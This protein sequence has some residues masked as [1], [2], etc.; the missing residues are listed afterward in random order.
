MAPT[1]FHFSTLLDLQKGWHNIRLPGLE[2]IF[3]ISEVEALISI[4]EKT[5]PV[6]FPSLNFTI[7]QI[8][9]KDINYI[10]AFKLTM[11]YELLF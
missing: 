5:N 11:L 4:S 1:S 7:S 3:Q 2:I 6:A 10:N 9:I 8:E